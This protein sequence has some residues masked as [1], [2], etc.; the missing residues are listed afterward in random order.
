MI[1]TVRVSLNYA[2]HLPAL[3]R[4]CERTR[5][6]IL[7]LGLGLFSTPYLHYLSRLTGR[8]VVSYDNHAPWAGLFLIAEYNKGQHEVRVVKEWDE[9]DIDNTEWAVALVD[10]EP[11]SRRTQEIRRLAQRAHYIIAHDSNNR[12]NREYRYTTIHKLFRWRTDWTDDF[13][14]AT[15]FSNFH[16][17]GDFWNVAQQEPA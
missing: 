15:V 9:A 2:T 3:M 16:D 17:L 6:P 12:Y 8:R 4:A 7:E 10:H 14:M 1:A 5:G 11:G 13:R